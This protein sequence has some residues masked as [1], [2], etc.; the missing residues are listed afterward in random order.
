MDGQHHRT[1]R[2]RVRSGRDGMHQQ[3]RSP[4]PR[5]GGFRRHAFR[6][7][8]PGLLQCLHRYETPQERE[9]HLFSGQDAGEAEQADE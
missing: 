7:G 5:T 9:P 4:H 6:R 2:V 3:R 1:D 8:H